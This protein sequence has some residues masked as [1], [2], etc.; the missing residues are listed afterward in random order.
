MTRQ[1]LT[2]LGL[3]LWGFL[4]VSFLKT[5]LPETLL[6]DIAF[7]VV[8]W[9]AFYPWATTLGLRMARYWVALA[10]AGPIA[11]AIQAF[12]HGIPFEVAS[13]IIIVSLF[14]PT[15]VLVVQWLRR[16]KQHA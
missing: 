1:S 6:G 11:I 9:A 14:L 12:K 4:F 16:R 13:G 10:V 3:V 15:T 7:T 8:L 5:Q 2:R